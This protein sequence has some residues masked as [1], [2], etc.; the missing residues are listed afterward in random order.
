MCRMPMPEDVAALW[1]RVREDLRASLPAST[2][3]LWLE[4][5]RA[6]SAQGHTLYLSARPRPV[7]AWVERRY[8]RTLTDALRRHAGDDDARSSSSRGARRQPRRR[9]EADDRRAARLAEPAPPSTTS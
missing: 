8:E 5:L 4:P 2:F 7:R 6:V 9:R 3:E 1:E